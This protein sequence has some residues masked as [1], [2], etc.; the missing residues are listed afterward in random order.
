MSLDLKQQIFFCELG[1]K[2]N[3]KDITLLNLWKNHQFEFFSMSLRGVLW[4]PLFGQIGEKLFDKWKKKFNI[5]LRGGLLSKQLFGQLKKYFFLDKKKIE[6]HWEVFH[7]G[8]N[9]LVKLE[10]SFHWKEN[11]FSVRSLKMMWQT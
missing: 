2:I 10:K 9:C 11:C 5:I 4:K 3:S 1:I 8:N 7:F 6:H